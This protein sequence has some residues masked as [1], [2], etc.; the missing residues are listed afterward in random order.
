MDRRRHAVASAA[1]IA[2][3]TKKTKKIHSFFTSF[4]ATEPFDGKR[5]G[6]FYTVRRDADCDWPAVTGVR[7]KRKQR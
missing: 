4:I 6:N 3:T 1:K 5:I 7:R 2:F